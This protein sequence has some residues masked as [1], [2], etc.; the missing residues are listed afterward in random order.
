MKGQLQHQAVWR[1]RITRTL[2]SV[3]RRGWLG[4]AALAVAILIT[5]TVLRGMTRN[6]EALEYE[7]SELRQG[8]TSGSLAN[9]ASD[10]PR[11]LPGQAASAD[12][13]NV[14]H[15][16]AARDSVRIDR[17]E[18]QLQREPGKPILVYRA[19]LVAIAPYLQLRNWLDTILRE[20]P[21][22]AIEELVFERPNADVGEV[23]AR[24]R[25]ALFMKGEP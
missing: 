9:G 19:D 10:L 13:A 5:A 22:V 18:Y 14:L 4:V 2:E 1:W 11:L 25:L 16:L 15:S 7:L 17:M 20:Q 24:V 3:G 8:K 23:T 6:I 12:F 21:T